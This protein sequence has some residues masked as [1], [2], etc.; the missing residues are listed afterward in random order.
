MKRL[1]NKLI[2]SMFLVTLIT[3]MGTRSTALADG[4]GTVTINKRFRI[5]KQVRLEGD[6]TWK[7]KVYIDLN[8]LEDVN[9]NIEFK[10]TVKNLSDEEA[11]EFDNMRME[12]ILPNE[13]YR[14]GGDGLTEYWNNFESGE[15]VTF[16]LEVRIEDE[17]LDREGSFEKCVVNKAEVEWDGEFEGS[18]TA[19]VCF[20]N[21]ELEELPETGA[22]DALGI[23]GLGLIAVGAFIRKSFKK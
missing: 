8:D 12:D 16:E 5:E 3:V 14:V 15:K 4:Y 1:A 21:G 23:T 17:E 18:D 2:A 9:K 19:T 20:G 11:D 7:D 6:S 22:F 13:L 10:I